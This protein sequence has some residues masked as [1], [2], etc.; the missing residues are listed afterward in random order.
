MRHIH[1]Y[2]LTSQAEL[3]VSA[4]S[5]SPRD[6]TTITEEDVVM[7]QRDETKETKM[8]NTQQQQQKLDKASSFETGT[9]THLV[10]LSPESN[11]APRWP[12]KETHPVAAADLCLLC[13]E[14]ERGKM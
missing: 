14:R 2:A 11:S 7:R 12:F 10:L 4:G 6:G 13:K 9:Y 8:R 3:P 1:I 5:F